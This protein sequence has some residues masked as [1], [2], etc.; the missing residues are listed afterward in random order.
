MRKSNND[1]RT[2][3]GF[4]NCI[5]D[6]VICF[7]ESVE[8]GIKRIPVVFNDS[9]GKWCLNLWCAEAAMQADYIIVQ[10]HA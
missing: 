1:T 10:D 9:N 6:L 3:G 8:K 7:E 2:R 5:G 4:I